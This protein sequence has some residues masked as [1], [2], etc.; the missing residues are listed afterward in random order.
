MSPDSCDRTLNH[1]T[2]F[3]DDRLA[4]FQVHTA[5][6]QPRMRRPSYLF[7]R[8][9]AQTSGCAAPRFY[10]MDSHELRRSRTGEI[11]WLKP[12]TQ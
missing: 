11:P 7:R 3:I 4:V 2:K 12:P 10:I 6:R 9:R 1:S 5:G 8:S